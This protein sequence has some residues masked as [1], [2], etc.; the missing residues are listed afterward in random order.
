MEHTLGPAC[1]LRP[2]PDTDKEDG[3]PSVKAQFFYTAIYPIDDPLSSSAT[4]SGADSKPSKGPLRPFSQDD[5]DMLQ[6][7]WLGLMSESL[8]SQHDDIR[9]GREPAPFAV[10]SDLER[11]DQ[12]VRELAAKHMR[13]HHADPQTR[14]PTT[15]ATEA[16][17]ETL[18]TACCPQLATDALEELDTTFCS[19]VRKTNHLFHVDEVVKDVVSV[20][21][22]PRELR[23]KV[24][25][26][27]R[28]API[29]HPLLTRERSSNISTDLASPPESATSSSPHE[30]HKNAG[31]RRE[32]HKGA[33][34][35][36]ERILPYASHTAQI[37]QVRT[38]R[39]ADTSEYVSANDDGISGRPF[40]RVLSTEQ[41]PQQKTAANRRRSNE[42]TLETPQLDDKLS[43][44]NNETSTE[45]QTRI[46]NTIPDLEEE[47]RD[48]V[49]GL[50]RLHKV[51]LYTLQMKPIYWSPVNDIAVV[52]RGTWFYKYVFAVGLC[53]FG[54]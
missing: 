42:P 47:S 31:P 10:E 45:P 4:Y 40:A 51:S 27:R 18:L 28:H 37:S 22:Q 43:E 48:V 53:C 14:K 5:N 52:T 7:A 54:F 16:L 8:R 3:V 24:P 17:P 33:A 49:V 36:Q 20:M 46:E 30:E 26:N 11:R 1:R 21:N 25:N 44:V 41:P 29:R 35:P 50:A 34:Y 12:V 15:Q 38:S 9:S 23:N 6:Q 19:L 39:V 2:T 32:I 13:I